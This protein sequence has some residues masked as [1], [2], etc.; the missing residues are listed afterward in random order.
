MKYYSLLTL[1]F[2]SFCIPLK[3]Q[4]E[5]DPL[6]GNLEKQFEHVFQR[7]QK[8][9]NY[10][11][12]SISHFNHLKKSSSDTLKLYKEEV[13]G[14]ESKIDELTNNG[15]ALNKE[16]QFRNQEIEE[17]V[18]AQKVVSFLGININKGLFSTVIVGVVSALLILLI[19]F[20]MKFKSAR[21][22]A[23]D[24]VSGL[25]RLEDEYVD[26]KRKAMEKEQ[27][28]GRKLQDEINKNR[29]D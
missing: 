17:L 20:V 6:K 8:Y 26:Y 27:Q 10:K 14:L 5:S 19:L 24:A 4:E 21:T 3:A 23:N 25:S 22:Q 7:S 12:I 1:L 9:Q 28:L 16:L 2:L 18:Q 29:K 15:E 13:S 11:V